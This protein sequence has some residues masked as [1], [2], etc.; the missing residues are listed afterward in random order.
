MASSRQN[1]QSIPIDEHTAPNI[2]TND[3][4]D[5]YGLPRSLNISVPKPQKVQHEYHIQITRP[6]NPNNFGQQTAKDSTIDFQH[7]FPRTDY[8]I[9]NA[10]TYWT[11][12]LTS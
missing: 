10:P 6:I 11:I 12:P 7:E 1:R 3:D 2:E 5:R 8:N 9:L 4:E